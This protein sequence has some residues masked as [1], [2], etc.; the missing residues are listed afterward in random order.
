MT[1]KLEIIRD[2]YREIGTEADLWREGA[3]NSRHQLVG[4]YHALQEF[5][6]TMALDAVGRIKRDLDEGK[7]DGMEATQV[8]DYAI[9]AIHT[10]RLA[11]E[12]AATHRANRALAV[13]GE[14][15]AHDRL[16]KT[17][18]KKYLEKTAQIEARER[19]V[20]SGAVVEEEDGTLSQA[21]AGTRRV[22]GARPAQGIA[23]QRKA[24]AAADKAAQEAE[25][26]PAPKKKASKKKASKKKE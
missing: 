8:A 10:A 23:A 26:E 2:V 6:K 5:A 24:E 13:A 7:L 22:P 25:A 19:A 18:E 15:Q 11:M 21:E 1:T 14:V 17:M 20:A 16:V 4:G 3:E 9:A 12:S